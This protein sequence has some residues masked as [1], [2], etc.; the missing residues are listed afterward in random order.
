MFAGQRAA[1]RQRQREHRR[2]RRL[3]ARVLRGIGRV[4]H[5]I[6]VQIA[7]AGVAET[8]DRQRVFLREL[9]HPG[10]QRGNPRHRHHHVLVDLAGCEIPQRGRQRLARRPQPFARGVVGG[11]FDSQTAV[12]ARRRGQCVQ[13]MRQRVRVA[14][15]FDHQQRA[16][17]VRNVAVSAVREHVIAR[18]PHCVAIHEFQHRRRDRLRHQSRDR[19]CRSVDIAIG[20]PQRAARGRQR[21]EAQRRFHDQRQRAFAADQ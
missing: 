1:Q 18:Q 20:R 6:D 21:G 14:V 15:G 16:D 4:V 13:G 11:G 5:Q 7:V 17:I 2:H 8:H 12:A 3:R 19:C 9:L 10:H